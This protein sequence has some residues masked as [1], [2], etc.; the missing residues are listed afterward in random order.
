MST[1]ASPVS[2]HEGICQQESEGIDESRLERAFNALMI[3]AQGVD[4][5]N[6]AAMAGIMRGF[7]EKSGLVLSDTMEA[8][9]SRMEKGEDPDVIEKEMAGLFDADKLFAI[10]GGNSGLSSRKRKLP[11]HDGKLYEL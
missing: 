1:F 5:G 11:E 3:E 9:F 4:E 2:D 8:A 10:E 6:S 7:T